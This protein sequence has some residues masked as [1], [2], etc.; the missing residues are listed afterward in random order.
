MR[1]TG[2]GGS[3]YVGMSSENVCEKQTRRK[4]K[5][6]W[7]RLIRPGLVVPKPR[8]KGV[9]DGQAVNIRLLPIWRYP[10]SFLSL[11]ENETG[12]LFV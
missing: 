5:V 12:R 6:S 4:S 8:P 1:I 3:D 11:T 10:V 9:G 7:G 2:V